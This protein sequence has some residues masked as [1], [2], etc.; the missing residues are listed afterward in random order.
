MMKV[1][2]NC[3]DLASPLV[4]KYMGIIDEW[5]TVFQKIKIPHR[6]ILTVGLM[7]QTFE[8]SFP[9]FILARC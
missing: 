5:Y 1:N 6:L 4:Y 2:L 7:S 8:L 9:A 3:I